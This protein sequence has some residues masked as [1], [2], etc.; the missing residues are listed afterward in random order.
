MPTRSQT[1]SSR[2]ARALQKLTEDDPALGAL[3]L[4]CHHRDA[5]TEEG[6]AWTAGEVIQYGP[7]FE[8]LAPHE[9]VGLAAHHILHVAFRHG[10]RAHAMRLRFGER[11]HAD[12]YNIAADAIVNETLL[13]A[14]YAL[15][16]PA[17]TLGPLL[18]RLGT[19]KEAREMALSELDSDV[20]Y[21]ML[22]HQRGAAG[23]GTQGQQT[24]GPSETDRRA[25]AVR[26]A[27]AEMNFTTDLEEDSSDPATEAASAKAAEWRQRLTMAME[28]G[29]L[30][31]RG[32]GALWF[33]LSDLPEATTPWETVLRGLV[34][35]ALT[36]ARNPDYSRPSRR[37]LAQDAAART[38]GT[39][40]PVFQPVTRQDRE[41]PRI[42][43]GLDSSGSIDKD[44]LHIFAAQ[45][46]GIARRM[47]AELHLLVFDEEVR[48][49]TILRD[50]E[51]E[52]DIGEVVFARDGGTTFVDVIEQ[53]VALGPS[54]IVVLTDLDGPFGDMVPNCPVIWA[55]PFAT[56]ATPPFGQ[57]LSLSR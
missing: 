27:A 15:P 6:L 22:L 39:D 52:R 38:Q 16:R 25:D 48:S 33:Q 54:A 19:P 53:A 56:S 51:M 9:Q 31:G 43:V 23:D 11:Y 7:G 46:A 40:Q 49:A 42:V 45:V 35:R 18:E 21:M 32:I 29:R 30:A 17:V 1:H 34:T 50:A 28:Q 36:R 3:A 44:R 47:R 13:K 8:A 20:I 5:A 37:W 10:P 41:I 2:A 4:W 26:T 57:L 24:E 14:G 12:V 55:V